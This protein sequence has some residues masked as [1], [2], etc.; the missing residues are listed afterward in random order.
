MERI[1][2]K[3]PHYDLISSSE[4]KLGLYSQRRKM[5]NLHLK[6]G[7]RHVYR[8]YW[9][10]NKDEHLLC[11]DS[12]YSKINEYSF[13]THRVKEANANIT[14][15]TETVSNNTVIK[16]SGVPIPINPW[17]SKE[18]EMFYVMRQK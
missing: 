7:K 11:M 5:A 9:C 15:L 12:W 2:M 18:Y 16:K 17:D 8:F 10:C 6:D 13:V 14:P 3:H 4:N 1:I